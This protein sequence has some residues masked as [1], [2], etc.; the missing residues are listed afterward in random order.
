MSPNDS[1]PAFAAHKKAALFAT[2]FVNYNKPATA[3][4][5]RAVPDHI[6]VETKVAYPGC[7]GMPFPE[8]AELD[9]VAEQAAKVSEAFLPLDRRRL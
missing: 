2:C 7:C 1:A 4:A 5:A 9:R 3:L 6:G 8:Q